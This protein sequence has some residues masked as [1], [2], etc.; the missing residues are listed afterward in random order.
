MSHFKDAIRQYSLLVSRVLGDQGGENVLVAQ[1]MTH[2]RG[3]GRGS[4]VAGPSPRNQ[5]F[6]QVP[7]QF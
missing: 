1:F 5:G 2:E 7:A 3:E 6:P 4:F